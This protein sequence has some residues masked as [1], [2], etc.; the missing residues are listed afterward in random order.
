MCRFDMCNNTMPEHK[1]LGQNVRGDEAIIMMY[2]P[3]CRLDNDGLT[4]HKKTNT[5]ESCAKPTNPKR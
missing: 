3:P 4:H 1:K 5:Y 2:L